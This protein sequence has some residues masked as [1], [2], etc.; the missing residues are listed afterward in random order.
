MI[1]QTISPANGASQ[2]AL[3]VLAALLEARTGQQI[4]AYRS[5][6]I[7]IALKPLLR[8]RG[9]TTL[10][11][12]VGMLMEGSDRRIADQIIDLLVNQETSFFRDA[13]VFDMVIDAVA[14]IEARGRRARIWCA[15]CSTGQEPYSLAMLFAERDGAGWI[16]PDIVATDVSDAAIGRAREGRYTQFEIQRGLPVRRMINWFEANGDE[17]VARAELRRMVAFRKLNL[18]GDQSPPGRFD[19]ILCRNVMLYLAAEPKAAIFANFAAAL[20]PGGILALGAG[21]TVIGQTRMFEPSKSYRGLYEVVGRAGGE[22]A[23]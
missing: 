16:A 23:S 1:H 6:R 5:W 13:P 3:G 20:E 22:A 11:Q 21:E 17:W 7:D 4:S 19:I 14:Q 18:L 10:D 9:L 12:L 15:G 2:S 8:D